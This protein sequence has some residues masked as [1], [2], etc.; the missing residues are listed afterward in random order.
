[1]LT[2]AIPG[3]TG[4]NN[5]QTLSGGIFPGRIIS[6]T[7]VFLQLCVVALSFPWSSIQPIEGCGELTPSGDCTGQIS[8]CVLEISNK[9]PHVCWRT[10]SQQQNHPQA[11]ADVCRR[12][13]WRDLSAL[14][15]LILSA[16]CSNQ[17]QRTQQHTLL[18]HGHLENG[19][20]Q[21]FSLALT[22][23][24]EYRMFFKCT[25]WLKAQKQLAS[26]HAMRINND[27]LGQRRWQAQ[28]LPAIIWLLKTCLSWEV[29]N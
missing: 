9:P 23:K 14:G 8:T 13:P 10:W 12:W 11:W 16:P 17:S 20:L 21:L 4:R 24:Q 19:Y 27:I 1:M 25:L 2:K 26:S 28:L 3:S 15:L 6:L 29:A 18:G 22:R 7:W 5:S